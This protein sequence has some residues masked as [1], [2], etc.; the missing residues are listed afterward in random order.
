MQTDP[1]SEI[2]SPE[3]SPPKYFNYEDFP[4]E[5]IGEF[6]LDLITD[7]SWIH[8]RIE[9]IKLLDLNQWEQRVSLDVDLAKLNLIIQKHNLGNYKI[10]PIPLG[11]F[12]KELM[13]DFDVEESG[14]PVHLLT[15][16]EDSRL[17]A[18][19]ILSSLKEEDATIKSFKDFPEG[20]MD[21][22]YSIVKSGNLYD[23]SRE[24][25]KDFPNNLAASADYWW[26]RLENLYYFPKRIVRFYANY[27]PMIALEIN[28]PTCIIKYR[29]LRPASMKSRNFGKG[30]NRLFGWV[31][32]GFVFEDQR[33]GYARRSH[34][35]I[36]APEGVQIANAP[37]VYDFVEE[38]KVDLTNRPTVERSVIYSDMEKPVSPGQYIVIQKMRPKLDIFFYGARYVLG[39]NL[40][41][42][43]GV[44]L[45]P[46]I[47]DSVSILLDSEYIRRALN[48]FMISAETR[49]FITPTL[50]LFPII[51]SLISVYIAGVREHPLRSKMLFAPRW[52][53]RAVAVATT[54]LLL[55]LIL[56]SAASSRTI[57]IA[58]AFMTL[59][60]F[61]SIQVW[62]SRGK[63]DYRTISNPELQESLWRKLWNLCSPFNKG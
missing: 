28:K 56:P 32:T 53:I 29:L 2:S 22:V 3:I 21:R 55:W 17:T 18:Y 4:K 15:S 23:A 54:L 20:I 6:I 7:F 62:I 36:C 38:R 51:P 43:L 57:W 31:G 42:L 14:L 24:L 12:T 35:R 37:E 59:L 47:R 9:T 1:E 63:R 52:V 39:F 45:W 13:L 30:L 46:Q 49:G 48:P 61:I 44:A 33:F 5:S 58:L 40:I 19:A 50:G 11:I 8:R 34:L 26:E 60:A 27:I 16:E 10:L 41:I 25:R